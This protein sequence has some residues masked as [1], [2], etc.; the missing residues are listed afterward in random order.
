MK[1]LQLSVLFLTKY[2]HMGASSR[3]RFFQ[4]FGVL[5]SLGVRC[6]ASP[7]FT[8]DYLLHR[9]ALGRGYVSDYLKALYR[10]LKSLLCVSKYDVVVIEKEL[11]PYFPSI[12]E[13]I[14]HF[15]RIPYVVDYDDAV[16]HQYDLHPNQVLRF[17]L[18]AKIPQV[19]R[20]ASLVTAGNNYLADF[21]I[22]AGAKRVE[23]VPTVIDLDRYPKCSP[24]QNSIFT[25][26]WIGSPTSSHNLRSIAPALAQLC[27]DGRARVVLIGSGRVDLPGV[28]SEIFDWRETEEVAFMQSFDVGIMP[29]D[30]EPFQRGKCGFKLI[31]Y[32]GCGIPV[33]ASPV[34]VNREIVD[35]AENGFLAKTGTE[36]FDY[37]NALREN[38]ELR[39]KLGAAGRGKVERQYCLG[40]VAPRLASL[41]RSIGG[42][43]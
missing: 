17:L 16:F 7:F 4:F 8:D 13:N 1:S 40:V 21:A 20:N 3:Y 37:L 15:A 38:R 23:V 43:I 24:P 10:R 31:Q 22:A 11:L 35:H 34:S 5:E 36:W 42:S 33:V 26:G 29:L 27:A 32:M 2:E 19:M 39:I 18:K 30:D 9:Y 28:P 6:Q 12:L 25:I 41:L 14:F